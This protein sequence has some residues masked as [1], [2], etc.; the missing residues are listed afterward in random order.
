M[1]QRNLELEHITPR[2]KRG[3]HTDSNL[4]LLCG[5]C[6][7]TK[8]NRDMNYPRVRLREMV[9][10]VLTQTASCATRRAA[11]RR[12]ASAARLHVMGSR[13]RF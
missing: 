2:S 6:N 7:R 8:G 1:R 12:E 5:W 10:C 4:Q 3:R 11:Q 9:G 13:I